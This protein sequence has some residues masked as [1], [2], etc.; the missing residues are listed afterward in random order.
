MYSWSIALHVKGLSLWLAITGVLAAINCTT[1][2]LKDQGSITL[3]EGA[4]VKLR[5]VIG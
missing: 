2:E 5:G 3:I 1:T 4:L